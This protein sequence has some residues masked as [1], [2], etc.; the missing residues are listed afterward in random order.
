MAAEGV[1]RPEILLSTPTVQTVATASPMIVSTPVLDSTRGSAN[2][3]N[4]TP[5]KLIN[6]GDS[7]LFRLAFGQFFDVIRKDDFREIFNHE[8]IEYYSQEISD[9]GPANAVIASFSNYSNKIAYWDNSN[10]AGNFFV[11][12]LMSKEG[13]LIFSEAAGE[14]LIEQFGSQE[15]SLIWSPDDLHLIIRDNRT[16][17]SS[18]IYS[19]NNDKLTPWK[20]DC[21]RIAISPKTTRLATWCSAFE[22]DDKYAVVEW[23]GDIWVSDSA[24]EQQIVKSNDSQRIWSFSSNGELV[25]FF[26]P[27]NDGNLSLVNNQGQI[28][29]LLLH[30]AWWENNDT[31]ASKISIPEFPIQ[32]SAN[33]KKLLV[34]ANELEDAR[35]PGWEN[36]S[37]NISV[38]FNIPCWHLINLE[39]S[40]IEWSLGDSFQ[41]EYSLYWQFDTA[42]LSPNGKYVAVTAESPGFFV[43]YIINIETMETILLDSGASILKWGN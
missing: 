24:P 3:L 16:L 20:W 42:A 9:L 43:T 18:M 11:Y 35:C 29:T 34:F 38:K 22:S 25:A 5:T 2:A 23:G 19:V 37:A 26:D 31:L 28:E 39:T 1:S 32:F 6:S 36:I 40:A 41:E 27:A 33:G 7:S 8:E 15:L 13:Q 4:Q 30:A 10:E 17:E 12:D 14:Y 21:D